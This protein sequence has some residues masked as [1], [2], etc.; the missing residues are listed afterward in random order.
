LSR[1][2]Q[3]GAAARHYREYVTRMRE[4]DVRPA[5]FPAAV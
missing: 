4:I 5:A 2:G 3:H 1:A